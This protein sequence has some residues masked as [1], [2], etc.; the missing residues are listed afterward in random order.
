MEFVQALAG[1]LQPQP[2]S[3]HN[4]GAAEAGGAVLLRGNHRRFR[5]VHV[6]A[7]ADFWVGGLQRANGVSK[8]DEVVL[9]RRMQEEIQGE[10]YV[11]FS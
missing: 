6:L 7:A 9:R 2:K 3:S 10:L 8:V 5:G 4:H 1:V 11:F